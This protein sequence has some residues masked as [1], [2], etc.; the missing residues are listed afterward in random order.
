MSQQPRW[1]P[2]SPPSSQTDPFNSRPGRS[3]SHSSSS[4]HHSSSNHNA[5]A[6]YAEYPAHL[7]HAHAHGATGGGAR[8]AGMM[9]AG[10]PGPGTPMHQEDTRLLVSQPSSPVPADFSAALPPSHQ[11]QAQGQGRNAGMPMRNGSFTSSPLN[12]GSPPTHPHPQFPHQQTP[13]YPA[14][15][16]SSS[17]PS[18]LSHTPNPFSRSSSQIRSPGRPSPGSGF[19][20]AAEDGVIATLGLGTHTSGFPTSMDKGSMVLYRLA[21][22]RSSSLSRASAL[23]ASN[24]NSH[25]KDPLLPPPR[26]PQG[27]GNRASFASSSGDSIMSVGTSPGTM[28]SGSV[29]GLIPYAYDPAVDENEPLDEED[30]LH[31]PNPNAHL[32]S[33]YRAV[34]DPSSSSSSRG[35]RGSSEKPRS[36]SSSKL[37]SAPSRSAM[38]KS[39]NLDEG[40]GRFGWRG[41]FNIGMLALLILGLLTL[42]VFYPVFTFYRDRRF[43]E[44]V[45]GNIRINGTGQAPVLFQMPDPIDT[46]TPDSAKTR[47]GYDGQQYELV[48]SDEFN[49]PGRTFYP[50]VSSWFLWDGWGSQGGDG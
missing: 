31:D 14:F 32:S 2:Q 11:G 25:S 3:N 18:S 34:M 26:I 8:S 30:L 20:S 10:T 15:A 16:S 27:K 49:T 17:T 33:K 38:V 13:P 43:N 1:G 40:T 19:P 4:T 50:G 29:R 36:G 48:F 23:S 42:F 22:E 39:W 41:V 47:T 6:Q 44:A 21:D 12:P 35:G 24:S 7:A 28:G 45:E 9:S 5:E 46:E 37:S